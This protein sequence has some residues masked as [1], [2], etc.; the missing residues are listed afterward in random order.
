MGPKKG[1]FRGAVVNAR[2]AWV[3]EL[4]KFEIRNPKGLARKRALGE[5][6]YPEI[7]ARPPTDRG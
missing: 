5:N 2:G 3:Q 7:G 6:A 1:D 4:K